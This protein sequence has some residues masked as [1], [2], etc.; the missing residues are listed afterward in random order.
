MILQT[1]FECAHFRLHHLTLRR[2][3]IVYSRLQLRTNQ[4]TKNTPLILLRIQNSYSCNTLN[5]M[6]RL[7]QSLRCNHGFHFGHLHRTTYIKA[8]KDFSRH[9]S[10]RLIYRALLSGQ[11]L[12]VF[13]TESVCEFMC[14]RKKRTKTKNKQTNK[15]K[16]KTNK[17]TKHNKELQPFQ[18]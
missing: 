15:N 12:S 17:T 14:R 1:K 9:A 6:C 2:K 16:N 11:R 3:N 8:C 5:C 18:R 13:V 10:S 4:H 7:Q